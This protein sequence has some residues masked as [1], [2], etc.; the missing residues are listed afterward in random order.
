MS[1]KFNNPVHKYRVIDGDTVKVCIDLGFGLTLGNPDKDRTWY[2]IRLNG[3]DSPESRTKAVT[4]KKA[5][6]IVGRAVSAWILGVEAAGEALMAHSVEIDDKYNKRF[7]GDLYALDTDRSLVDYLVEHNLV[8]PYAGGTKAEWSP[9]E[10][11]HII[12][13]GEEHLPDTED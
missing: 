13:W 3:I 9:D 12:N 1:K 4:E 6:K 5:G 8:R 2:S 10:L 11:A 7:L